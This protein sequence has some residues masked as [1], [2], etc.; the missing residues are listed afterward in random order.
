[1]STELVKKTAQYVKQ[2][3]FNEHTGHDWYHVQRVWR[4]AKQLQSEEGGNLELVEL[5]SLLHDL[6]DY[7]QYDFNERKGSLVLH[8]MM[9]ILE[10]EEELQKKIVAITLES[11]YNGDDTKPA[12]TL[13]GRIVQDADWLDAMGAIGISRIFANGGNIKRVIHDPERKPRRRLTKKIYQTKKQEGTSFNYFYEKTLKL[14][15]LLNTST[16]KIIGK[17]RIKFVKLFLER[18]LDEWNGKK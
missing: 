7:K 16:A 3:L 10:I 13:E 18:F 6:G 2:K 8:G 12:S 14:P 5:A 15:D 4:L 1:M 11:Q 9:D 17:E